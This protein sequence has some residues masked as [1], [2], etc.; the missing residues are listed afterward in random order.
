MRKRHNKA[1]C[2]LIV[3]L[4]TVMLPAEALAQEMDV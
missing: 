4:M 2:L 3:C 1:V